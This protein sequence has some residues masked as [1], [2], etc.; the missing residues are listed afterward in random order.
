LISQAGQNADVLNNPENIKVLANILKTNVAATVSIGPGFVS[1]IGRIFLDLLG[2]YKAVGGLVSDAVIQQGLIA[3]K[4]PRVRGYRTIKKEVLKLMDVYIQKA[5]DLQTV[6]QTMIPP[7]LESVLIDYSQNVEPAKEAEVLNVMSNIITRFKGLISDKVG[8]I[9]DSVFECTL[10][11]INKNFEEYPEHRVG[12]FKLL[13]AINLNCFQGK[14]FINK[15]ILLLAKPQFKMFMDSIVW[16]FK[17]TMREIGEIG[18]LICVDLLNNVSKCEIRVA[19]QFYADYYVNLLQDLFFVLTS[20]SH[21][22]GFKLQSMILLQ[23]FQ[24]NKNNSITVPLYDAAS[25][26]NVT[27]NQQYISSF[28]SDMLKSA[29]PHLQ[30]YCFLFI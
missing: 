5:D 12:F 10:N 22:S 7:L 25:F 19:N 30:P 14:S 13:Q 1:Q 18:L 21:K 23:M 8:P 16:S 2:L 9:L 3:T 4:T 27:S 28:L 26:P 20:T 29:F 6:Y 15:A 11:M 17:H 24:L